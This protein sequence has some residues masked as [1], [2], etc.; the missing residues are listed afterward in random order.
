V[1]QV[2]H[3]CIASGRAPAAELLREH[4]EADELAFARPSHDPRCERLSDR[5]PAE[6]MVELVVADAIARGE[7]R[8]GHPCPRSAELFGI[9]SCTLSAIAA[10]CSSRGGVRSAEFAKGERLWQRQTAGPFAR[11]EFMQKVE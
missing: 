8:A 2:A 6:V 1:L 7:R 4:L 9:C 5:S 10:A 11:V 3:R